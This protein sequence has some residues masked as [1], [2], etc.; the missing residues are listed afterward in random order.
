MYFHH[1]SLENSLSIQTSQN[2]KIATKLTSLNM[3]NIEPKRWEFSRVGIFINSRHYEIR[4]IDPCLCIHIV[5]LLKILFGFKQVKTENSHIDVTLEDSYSII[6]CHT[7]IWKSNKAHHIEHA[8]HWTQTLRI[9]KSRYIYQ[10]SALWNT[11][12]RSLFVYSY[13]HSLENSLWIQTSQNRKF[14]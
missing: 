1:H 2:K 4:P 3:Q 8:E 11:S 10:L 13:R 14:K 5:I 6:G 7:S 12:Y 9:F